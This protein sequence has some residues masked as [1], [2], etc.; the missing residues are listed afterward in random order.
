MTRHAVVQPN[1]VQPGVHPT[2]ST[3]VEEQ[4]K[5][6]KY[7]HARTAENARKV[8][9]DLFGTRVGVEQV[10]A[11]FGLDAFSDEALIRLAEI[12]YAEEW[13]T[14]PGGAP[15]PLFPEAQS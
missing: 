5:T 8:C 6:R 10:V 15:Y 11:E 12:Q 1:E 3:A 2:P 14:I 13:R 7:C 9:R 4:N